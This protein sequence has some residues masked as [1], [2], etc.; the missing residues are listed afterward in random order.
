M[1]RI[2]AVTVML[3]VMLV[4]LGGCYWGYEGR[5]RDGGGR[6]RDGR[7]E[8]S[9]GGHDRGGDREGRR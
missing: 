6:D 9:G 4:S 3:A 1:K 8:D 5:G 2:I 7:H